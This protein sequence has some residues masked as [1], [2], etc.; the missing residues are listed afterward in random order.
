MHDT[1]SPPERPRGQSRSRFRKLVD[2]PEKGWRRPAVLF[3]ALVGPGVLATLAN[4]DAGGM[5]SY[6]I[7]GARF[8]IGL[9]IPLTL[10]LGI[11]TYTT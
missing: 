4:N 9:F 6:T 3:W 11:A 5:I 7:T 1:L 10:C 2:Q 8:G